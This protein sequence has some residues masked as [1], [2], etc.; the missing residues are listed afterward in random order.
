MSATNANIVAVH[1]RGGDMRTHIIDGSASSPRCTR[2]LLSSRISLSVQCDRSW[3]A[4]KLQDTGSH[5]LTGLTA[6]IGS[7]DSLT[8]PPGDAHAPSARKTS[9]SPTFPSTLACE[10]R[11]PFAPTST[12][13]WSC[14]P[15]DAPDTNC[16][17]THRIDRS[18]AASI[19]THEDAN[20][21][22]PNSEPSAL[23]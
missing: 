4:P 20:A 13:S 10:V 22:P 2:G 21:V 1:T 15:T 11:R 17:L 6:G 5:S 14:S 19:A 12:W 9:R 8:R 18:V 23:I 16:A 3:S 7:N